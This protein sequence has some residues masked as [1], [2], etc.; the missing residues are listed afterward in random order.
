MKN[1]L[2]PHVTIYKFP[3]TALTSI[4]TRVT[5]VFCSRMHLPPGANICSLFW[6]N[7]EYVSKYQQKL[8]QKSSKIH[9]IDASGV[10][11]MYF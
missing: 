5:G 2:S 4:T 9:E 3:I 1:I 6:V 8:T 10:D 7:I 11:F